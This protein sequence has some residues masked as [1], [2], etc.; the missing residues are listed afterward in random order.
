MNEKDTE[1]QGK[2]TDRKEA[3]TE[4]KNQVYRVGDM[5]VFL[6]PMYVNIIQF[7]YVSFFWN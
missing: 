6:Y 4:D 5:L 1:R 2:E 7:P 3:S